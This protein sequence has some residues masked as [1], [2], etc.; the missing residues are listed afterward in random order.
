M[1]SSKLI[2]T[3]VLGMMI[4]TFSLANAQKIAYINSEKI[5][6]EYR[7]AV[8]SQQTIDEQ[9][10][11]WKKE[12]QA[13]DKEIL[14]LRN[15]LETQTL[16]LS[17]DQKIQKEKTLEKKTKALE[18]FRNQKWGSRG[19]LFT[20]AES[21][22]RRLQEK[23]YYVVGEV[24]SDEGYDYIIDSSMGAFVFF[25]KKQPDITDDVIEELNK[26]ITMQSTSRYY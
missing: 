23:I 22:W 10:E 3:A 17:E 8:E 14:S 15:H 11:Q 1:G 16:L 25:S 24:A 12:A 20:K 2:F 5:R 26:G 18:S 9:N 7:E 21:E 4:G 19:Q 6:K 13:M